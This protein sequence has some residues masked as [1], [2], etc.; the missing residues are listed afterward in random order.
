MR[1]RGQ[2]S[3]QTARSLY[4]SRRLR[5]GGQHELLF[6]K[7][8]MVDTKVVDHRNRK[9]EVRP[10]FDQQL[11][12]GRIV[13]RDELHRQVMDRQGTQ[14]ICDQIRQDVRRPTQM[15]RAREDDRACPELCQGM[16]GRI[17]RSGNPLCEFIS[18]D[19][20][21]YTARVAGEQFAFDLRLEACDVPGHGG[22]GQAELTCRLAHR[23]LPINLDE[24]PQQNDRHARRYSAMFGDGRLRSQCSPVV[25]RD[26]TAIRILPSRDAA[27][28]AMASV[29]RASGKIWS[30]GNTSCPVV[31][32]MNTSVTNASTW[33]GRSF[34]NALRLQ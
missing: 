30:T 15:D 2:A 23:T 16:L 20:R 17:K 9:G 7:D 25:R 21:F 22:L 32:S 12:R 11:D 33:S 5:R 29:L 19:G 1:R 6:A 4:R 27:L 10:A 13:R 31:T 3:G 18:D 8:L 34:S 28:A 26:Q 24:T 14:P